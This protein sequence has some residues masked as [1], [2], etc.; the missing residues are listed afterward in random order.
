MMLKI[1]ISAFNKSNM[2]FNM[3]SNTT[4]STY[5]HLK[6]NINYLLTYV[7]ILA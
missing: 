1:K 5:L 7:Q 2:N 3:K 6:I 4:F